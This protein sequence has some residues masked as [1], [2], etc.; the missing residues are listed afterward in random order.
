MQ[1]ITLW[2]LFQV[3]PYV[4]PITATD[5]AYTCMKLAQEIEDSRK[6]GEEVILKCGKVEVLVEFI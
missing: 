6:E 4:Q 3:F 5:T 2:I 1:T